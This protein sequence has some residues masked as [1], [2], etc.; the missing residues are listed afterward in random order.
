MCI[1]GKIPWVHTPDGQQAA[2]CRPPDTATGHG[3]DDG[4]HQDHEHGEAP[5]PIVLALSVTAL[6]TVLLF[7]L[8]QLPLDLARDMI[9]GTP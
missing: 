2:F 8:P 1:V 5:L 6:G 3:A 7:F 4:G 9:G